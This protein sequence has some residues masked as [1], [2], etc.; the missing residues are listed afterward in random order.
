MRVSNQIRLEHEEGKEGLLA[1]ETRK[2]DEYNPPL[3]RLKFFASRSSFL[4]IQKCGCLVESHS[5]CS[6]CTAILISISHTDGLMGEQD[7]NFAFESSMDDREH[8]HGSL[9]DS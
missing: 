4:E 6:I 8:I 9:R 5:H 3:L 7:R 1:Y 2:H